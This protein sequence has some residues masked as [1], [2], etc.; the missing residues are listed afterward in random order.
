MKLHLFSSHLLLA[1]FLLLFFEQI[2]H[3]FTFISIVVKWLVVFL[4]DCCKFAVGAV[5]PRF[6]R[7]KGHSTGVMHILPLIQQNV[8]S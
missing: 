1:V 4:T 2:P 7:C 5:L 3:F 8:I 6:L